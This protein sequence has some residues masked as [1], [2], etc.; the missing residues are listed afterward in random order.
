MNSVCKWAG[1]GEVARAFRYRMSQTYGVQSTISV[2]GEIAQAQTRS[3]LRESCA[4]AR[5]QEG[6]WHGS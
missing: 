6:S 4:T 1:T 3:H 2:S 5:M